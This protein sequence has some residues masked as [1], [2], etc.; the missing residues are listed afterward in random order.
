MNP[1]ILILT[2]KSYKSAYYPNSE[3]ISTTVGFLNIKIDS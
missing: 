2:K 1:N 3:N